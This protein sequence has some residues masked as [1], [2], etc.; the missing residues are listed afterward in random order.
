MGNGDA[1]AG[2]SFAVSLFID[3]M[4]T[5]TLCGGGIVQKFVA[6]IDDNAARTF[7]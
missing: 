6:V 4:K 5:M 2:F 1:P 7:G 3:S